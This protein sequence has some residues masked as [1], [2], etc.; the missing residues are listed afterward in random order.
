MGTKP[1][2]NDGMAEWTYVLLALLTLVTFACSQSIYEA[3]A[4]NPNFVALRVASNWELVKIVLVF[5]LL[6]PLV[7][8][9]IWAGLR[10]WNAQLAKEFLT[11]VCFLLF[12]AFFFQVHNL[13][14][15]QPWQELR[16]SY[17][18]WLVPAGGLAYLLLRSPR[19]FRSLVIGLSPCIVIFPALFLWQTWLPDER[20]QELRAEISAGS[21]PAAEVENPDLVS[22]DRTRRLPP[23]FL[24]VF[25]EFAVDA[26]LDEA[27]QIDVARF[28]AFHELGAGSYW[29]PNATANADSTLLS[30]PAIVTGN[31]PDPGKLP[32]AQNYPRNLFNWL[33]EDYDVY[34]YE[35]WERFCV[36]ERHHCIEDSSQGEDRGPSLLAD[37]YVLLVLR[38][39]P[40]GAD[41]ALP[42][43]IQV[44]GEF[45]DQETMASKFRDRFDGFMEAVGSVGQTRPVLFFFHHP[46]PH[47]PYVLEP[48]GSIREARH[49]SFSPGHRGNGAV[50]KEVLGRY[51]RQIACVDNQLG[52]FVSLLKAR[53]LYDKSL[54]IITADHGVSY[55]LAAP[56][57]ALQ[58]TQGI[59]LNADLVLGVP[60]F[61]K[62]PF[63]TE[64]VKSDREVQLIDIVP[65]VGEVAGLQVPWQVTGRSV[66]QAGPEQRS[67]IAYSFVGRRY[68]LPPVGLSLLKPGTFKV[69]DIEQSEALDTQAAR[70]RPLAHSWWRWR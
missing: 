36:A 20:S 3:L 26:L 14:Y 43:F 31:L 55:K 24:I 48:D 58:M 1:A 47:A 4:R 56:G 38:I 37:V 44:W 57:R 12:L 33:Q 70:K 68:E 29:F 45:Q 13:S 9:F 23:I 65:T 50:L 61:I 39:L 19:V 63:Q 25:D 54:L 34:A 42:I 35:W 59:L 28:P 5:N 66:F 7:L 6:P 2:A 17:L 32:T 51:K 69:E 8:F 11:L 15:L 21:L 27:G 46:L 18:V 41:F 62:L 52:R 30:M 16:N 49:S 67:K 60:L 53:G 10:R 22:S 40:K 64:G